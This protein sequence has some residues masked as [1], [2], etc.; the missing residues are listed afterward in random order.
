M[1]APDDETDPARTLEM[2]GG[3]M[4]ILTVTET[5]A[6]VAVFPAASRATAVRV[7]APLVVVLGSH[8]TAYG[9]VSTS[10]PR[11]A[12][13]SL[14]C[15]PATPTL[16]DAVAE[17]VVRPVRMDPARGAVIDTAGGVVSDPDPDNLTMNVSIRD[18]QPK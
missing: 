16:S 8:V 12:P 17:T 10:A 9:A 1:I 4:L 3:M 15:T 2:I 11:F 6:D 18:P 7:C 5:A 14:N 13:S